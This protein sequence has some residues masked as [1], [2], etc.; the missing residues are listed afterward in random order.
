MP[1][2][3]IRI[4][5]RL[6][7]RQVQ[8]Q[9][10]VLLIS[11]ATRIFRPILGSKYYPFSGRLVCSSG[12]TN[13]AILLADSKLTRLKKN[14][15][16]HFF[17]DVKRITHYHSET[18]YV[19]D[20]SGDGIILVTSSFRRCG[21]C[22]FAIGIPAHGLRP[23]PIWVQGDTPG[24]ILEDLSFD[25]FGA[26]YHQALLGS[27]GLKRIYVE[28][29][30][31]VIPD[32]QC[33]TYGHWLLELL[34]RIY[35]FMQFAKASNMSV[36]SLKFY[37]S[38]AG[39]DYEIE[40][41][42]MLGI[43]SGNVNFIRPFTH[44][45]FKSCYVPSVVSRGAFNVDGKFLRQFSTFLYERVKQDSRINNKD[46]HEGNREKILIL[47]EGESHRV[48][49]NE[50]NLREKLE[51]LDFYCI[52]PRTLSLAQKILLF[53]Q[54]LLLVAPV[55]SGTCNALFMRQN[56]TVIEIFHPDCVPQNAQTILPS[57]SI[58][59]F[60]LPSLPHSN[61]SGWDRYDNLVYDIDLIIETILRLESSN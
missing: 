34:P 58:K 51:E 31:V 39:E 26:R 38:G 59:H 1:F 52:N 46:A 9:I 2:Q 22:I 14:S 37:I 42:E 25:L 49:V 13:C 4:R 30:S 15:T 43:A 10:R 18:R 6:I 20:F 19:S 28:N 40:A 45:T 23:A 21:G 8:L 44:Y 36:D 12:L 7:Y 61:H 5:S 41:F 11:V 35:M 48:P 16:S 57:L 50:S 3:A 32:A 55:G 47:R 56:T 33:L 53:S 24:T 17:L 54:A 27:I 60:L 29:V